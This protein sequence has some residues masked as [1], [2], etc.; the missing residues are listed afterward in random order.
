MSYITD[1]ILRFLQNS[2]HAS[3]SDVVEWS[4][5][6]RGE[7]YFDNCRPRVTP[8]HGPA[9]AMQGWLTLGAFFT[10]WG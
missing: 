1:A 7:A 8:L 10:G 6:L 9:C 2:L 4:H 5:D 3:S